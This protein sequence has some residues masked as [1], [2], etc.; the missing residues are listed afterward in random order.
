MSANA[1]ANSPDSSG[2][3]LGLSGRV[4]A[5]TGA[6]SG[7]GA[8]IATGL[9][10]A[11]AHVALLD[12]NL[13]AADEIAGRLRATGGKALALACDVSDEAAVERAAVRLREALGPFGDLPLGAAAVEAA[14]ASTPARTPRKAKKDALNSLIDDEDAHVAANVEAIEAG[15][16]ELKH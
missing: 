15:I 11:G 7:I 6:G 10:G 2:Q 5:V 12:S 13:E 4:C 1:I 14:E 8:A 3:W 16:S 9:A